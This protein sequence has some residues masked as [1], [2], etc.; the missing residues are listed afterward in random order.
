VDP[1]RCL[2]LLLRSSLEQPVGFHG[3]V[4]WERRE[5]VNGYRRAVRGKAS[6]EAD[7]KALRLDA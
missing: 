3:C 6:Q 7:G 1:W 4:A 5:A 2:H